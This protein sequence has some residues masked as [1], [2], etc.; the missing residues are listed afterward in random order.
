VSPTPHRVTLLPGDGIG[1]E[2]IDAARLV[3]DESGAPLEWEVLDVGGPAVRRSGDALPA[4]V[5]ESVRRN[6]VALK[7][8]VTTAAGGGFRS[9]NIGLRRELG[10][11]CQARLCRS[12]P[13]VRTPFSPVDLVVMRETTE[14]LYAGVEMDSGSPGAL[15]LVELLAATG[16]NLPEGAGISIKY[17]SEPAVRRM[18][19]FA[20]DWARRNGRARVTVVHKAT[21]M[22]STDGLF[23]TAAR[24]VAA[25]YPDIE[26]DDCLVD[27]LAAQL[28]RCP[29]RYDVLLTTNLYGD[30]LSDLASGLVGGVGLVPGCNYGGGL[31]LFEPGHGSAPRHAGLGRVNPVATILSGAMMLRHLGETDAAVR[32]EGAVERVVAAGRCVTYDIAADPDRAVGTAAVAAAVIGAMR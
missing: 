26:V 14:D 23:L 21:V 32:V 3:L 9:V 13:G 22:R 17:V 29:D 30:I 12:F 4:A 11:Y 31:A 28:V 2:V 25:G 10:L 8:P 18:V 27:N 1:P 6:R 20:L 5:L 16:T 24:D 15:A 19:R 7:G